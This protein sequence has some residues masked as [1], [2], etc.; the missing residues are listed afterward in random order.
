M[1]RFLF[2][3]Q[4]LSWFLQI[5][6]RKLSYLIFRHYSYRDIKINLKVSLSYSLLIKLNML[7][8]NYYHHKQTTL[9]QI[10][11]LVEY[12]PTKA[13]CNLLTKLK[14]SIAYESMK[15]K[16]TNQNLSSVTEIFFN[17]PSVLLTSPL[18]NIQMAVSLSPA[19]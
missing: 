9:K 17:L 3:L 15:L 8:N 5:S 11:L 18:L 12:L 13:S 7:L 2:E 6:S 14:S 19:V 4:L 16:K 10:S 1:F